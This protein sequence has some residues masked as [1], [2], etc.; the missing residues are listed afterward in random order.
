MAFTIILCPLLPLKAFAP[1]E[2]I[3]V[4]AKEAMWDAT[5]HQGQYQG[6]VMIRQNKTVMT[7]DKVII[8]QKAANLRLDAYG[9]PSTFLVYDETNSPWEGQAER[10]IYNPLLHTLT[11]YHDAYLKH[12]EH[13]VKGP[14]INYAL[15]SHIATTVKDASV[16]PHIIL[17]PEE[18]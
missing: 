1:S 10:I 12:L 6:Q 17:H 4:D 9:T 2:P 15:D 11:L 7:A 8:T 3:I 5:L 16:R 13:V 14:E 18:P